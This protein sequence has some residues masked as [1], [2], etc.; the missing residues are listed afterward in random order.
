[1]GP[2]SKADETE[3]VRPCLDGR[4]AAAGFAELRGSSASKESFRDED[5]EGREETASPFSETVSGPLPEEDARDASS[6]E[7]RVWGANPE[8]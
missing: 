1:L 2:G 6:R 7:S 3:N 4:P 5:M 8:E